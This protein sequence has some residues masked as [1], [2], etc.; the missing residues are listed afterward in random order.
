MRPEID[1]DGIEKSENVLVSLKIL[2]FAKTFIELLNRN[3]CQKK[4]KTIKLNVNAKFRTTVTDGYFIS[5]RVYFL[6]DSN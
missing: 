4:K 2:S 6:V 3:R 5:F 1:S